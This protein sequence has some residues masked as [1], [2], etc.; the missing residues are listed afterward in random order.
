MVSRPRS[1]RRLLASVALAAT[2][3]L[4]VSGCAGSGSS[5]KQDDSTATFVVGQTAPIDYLNPHGFNQSKMSWNR[6]LYDALT[7]VDPDPQPNLAESWQVNEDFSDYTL[8]LAEG[9]TFHDGSPLTADIVVENLIWA[10]DPANLVNGGAL[11]A[12]A[13]VTAPD[14]LTVR[15]SFPGPAPQLLS[16][17][18]IVP[19]M[20]LSRDINV[21]PNGTGP[22]KLEKFIPNSVMTM[23]RNDSYWNEERQPKVG[24]YEVRVFSDNASATASLASGQVDVFAFPPFNQLSPLEAQGNAVSTQPAPGNFMIRVNTAFEPLKDERVR[25]ALSLAVDRSTFAQ[26]TG[27]DLIVPTCN[28]YPEAS[29][30]YLP[31]V[32]ASCEQDLDKAK[33]LLEEAGYGDGLELSI[34]IN[35]A[36]WPELSA[37]APVLQESLATIGVSLVLNEI[38]PTLAQQRILD[39]DYEL[40]VDWYPWGNLD[41]A[42]LFVTRTFT[43][44][45]TLE[46]FESPAYTELVEAAQI[47]PDPAKRAILYQELNQYMIDASF[48]I[49]MASRPYTYVTGKD[50]ASFEFD[51]FGMVIPTSLSFE[52]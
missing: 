19:I 37:Y 30:A 9:V 40:A 1:I 32:D 45:L 33:A 14:A 12:T 23:T 34:D 17:L 51:P 25:K 36:R 13:D 46:N 22:Y 2:A 28:I 31:D 39:S 49:P 7:I 43:P 50:V 48:V 8:T 35:S 10:A 24:T 21:D 20:D 3:G 41:P 6:A 4:V 5:L 27:T 26:L 52:D 47:E 11:L 18:A 29:E 16:T 15:M 44:G 42:L 38:T